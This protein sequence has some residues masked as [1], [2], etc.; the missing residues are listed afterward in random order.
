MLTSL[1]FLETPEDGPSYEIKSENLIEQ[2]CPISNGLGNGVQKESIVY[3]F[4]WQR[5]KI[6]RWEFTKE[7]AAEPF[8]FILFVYFF[9]CAVQLVRS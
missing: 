4:I 1:Y 3:S 6:P 7:V 8:Y 9:G 2:G 5:I